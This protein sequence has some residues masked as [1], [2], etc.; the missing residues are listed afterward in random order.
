MNEKFKYGQKVRNINNDTCWTFVG[1]DPRDSARAVLVQ[2]GFPPYTYQLNDLEPVRES[3][4]FLVV[5]IYIPSKLYKAY[6]GYP[7]TKEKAEEYLKNNN[8]DWANLQIIE[9]FE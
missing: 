4:G 2:R 8:L 9:V 7:V 6:T 5:G 1:I 3:K